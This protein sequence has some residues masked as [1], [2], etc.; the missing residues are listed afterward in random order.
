MVVVRALKKSLVS[1]SIFCIKTRM[2][3]SL[4]SLS[5]VDLSSSV[6]IEV[7]RPLLTN[8]AFMQ[9]VREKLPPVTG[10]VPPTTTPQVAEQFVATVQSPQFR[11]ALDAFS[12]AVQSG[13]LGP[14]IQQ[15]GLSEECVAA[16][17][18]GSRC[19][20]RKCSFQQCVLNGIT[21]LF[22]FFR[23]GRLLPGAAEEQAAQ[24]G[25]E[26]AR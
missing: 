14:V 6:N 25:G 12:A 7:L 11:Q 20:E 24:R 19:L 13:Q 3:I 8:D 9:R 23:P 2:L 5:A 18:N 4:I 26:K 22:P 16:A 21:K 17:N 1:L 10:G 15:F